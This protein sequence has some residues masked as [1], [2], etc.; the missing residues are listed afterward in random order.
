VQ[1]ETIDDS[2]SHFAIGAGS[3]KAESFYEFAPPASREE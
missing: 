3:P 1:R 2:V